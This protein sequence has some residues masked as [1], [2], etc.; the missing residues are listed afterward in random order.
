[1]EVHHAPMSATRR[2]QGFLMVCAK[3]ALHF[4]FARTGEITIIQHPILGPGEARHAIRAKPP[5][6]ARAIM[7]AAP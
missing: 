2:D 7:K 4:D 5:F 1:M 3:S 6:I